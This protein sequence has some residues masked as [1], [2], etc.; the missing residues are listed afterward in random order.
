MT[1]L[2]RHRLLWRICYTLAHHPICV[3]FH[4]THDN[5]EA[6]VPCLVISN[7]VTD[8][9]PILLAMSFPHTDLYFVASEHLFRKGW[10]SRF[11]YWAME[12]IS[13][14]KGSQAT[15]TVKACLRHLKEGHSVCIFAEGDATWD[16]RSTEVFPSTGKLARLSGAALLT[17]RLEGG[18]LSKPRWSRTMRRGAVY[19]HAV[20]L[21]MPE[22]LRRM[23]PEE[24]TQAINRDIQE[25][26]W[27]RQKE[28]PVLFRGKKL[29][30]C[31]ETALF[32]CP[33][34]RGLGTLRSKGDRLY[35]SC[36]LELRYLET[37][38]FDPPEPFEN[39]AQWEDW[40]QAELKTLKASPG[41]SLFSDDEVQLTVIEPGHKE[42][43]L[44]KGRLS[45]Y[46]DSL[47]F[48]NRSFSFSQIGSMAMVQ[49]H[50][51]LFRYGDTYYELRSDQWINFRKYLSWWTHYIT[52]QE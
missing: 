37:G 4:L 26:A 49:K 50:L 48:E 19:G 38:S 17:Y 41:E 12:P 9:D 21:Y 22:E 8:F 44:G 18:Y 42:K 2:T 14:Q 7:H 1:P 28:N 43:R 46:G 15:D 27:A 34:C 10:I 25:D 52:E 32:L 33:R 39:L 45:L 16:G 47:R 5:A 51:L 11:L 13:R 6:E 30:E 24:I 3:S 35:C 20:H 31:L 40:Q 29:A 36:G 23:R